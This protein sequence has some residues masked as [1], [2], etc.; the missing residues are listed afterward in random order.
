MDRP[1]YPDAMMRGDVLTVL[2]LAVLM[3]GLS[4]MQAHGQQ[5]P[6]TTLPLDHAFDAHP[7]AAAD[8]AIH[9]SIWQRSPWTGVPSAPR[10]TALAL[11]SPTG[12][13][14]LAWGAR[15]WSDV[16]GP[17]R[18][19]G[20]HAGLAYTTRW[21]DDLKLSL[22]LGLGWMQFSIDGTRIDLET[23]GDPVLGDT[24][25]AIGVP[26]AS[27]GLWIQ[28]E[29]LTAAFS[30]GQI[31]GGNL[32]VYEGTGVES[33]LE[34]HLRA[35]VA[36]R[37]ESGSLGWT[38]IVQVQHLRPVPAELSASL[39]VDKGREYWA[40]VGYRSAGAAHLGAGIRLNNQLTFS[41]NR[42]WATGS[43]SR[44][45]GGGHEVVLAFTVPR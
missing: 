6:V 1:H 31:L 43:L 42:N 28:G 35:M 32:P 24:Y 44:V 36:Y 27:A 9:V 12:S 29:K 4:A 8:S 37:F 33:R 23:A 7:A 41:Y 16:A 13:E 19:A 17:T 21:T 15:F 39:R 5:L 34:S 22:G 45:L 30:A 10:T 25:Q 20:L 40:M 38:P 11:T 3:C 18:M 2:K 26:D 14:S